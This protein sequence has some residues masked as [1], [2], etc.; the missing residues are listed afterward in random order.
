MF[1]SEFVDACNKGLYR[2]GIGVGNAQLDYGQ[3]DFP[4]DRGIAFRNEVYKY[5]HCYFR[6]LLH[7]LHEESTDKWTTRNRDKVS[8]AHRRSPEADY[9]DEP[10]LCAGEAVHLANVDPRNSHMR[11]VLDWLTDA[12][13]AP[14]E[15]PQRWFKI[16]TTNREHHAYWKEAKGSSTLIS[17]T[18][19]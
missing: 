18:L 14:A 12:Y 9:S 11:I 7:Y 10:L 2:I 15:V 4:A 8:Q 13:Q 16:V 6:A 17:H 5:P 3:Q 19:W 1:P